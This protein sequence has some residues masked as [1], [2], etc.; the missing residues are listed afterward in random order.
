MVGPPRAAPALVSIRRRLEEIDQALVLLV[1]ARVEAAS[2]A[3]R[4]RSEVD[5]R[6]ADPTQERVVLTRARGWA[7][8]VG[9]SPALA[10]TILRAIVEAG[11]ERASIENR[12]VNPSVEPARRGEDVRPS[13]RAPARAAVPLV[14]RPRAAATT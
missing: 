3:I 12:L 14:V 11:K 4:I 1:A 13:D 6:L 8:E 5:G 9:V 2:L 10:E 7:E